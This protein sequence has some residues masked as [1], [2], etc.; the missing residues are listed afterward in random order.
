[1]GSGTGPAR[2]SAPESFHSVSGCGR[3]HSPVRTLSPAL[4]I[5]SVR[6][7][8]TGDQRLGV[9][10]RARRPVVKRQVPANATVGSVQAFGASG[11][12]H[13]EHPSRPDEPTLRTGFPDHHVRAGTTSPHCTVD[14]DLRQR[15]GGRSQPG[16][17]HRRRRNR[18]SPRDTKFK[19]I[20]QTSEIE[21]LPQHHRVSCR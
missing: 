5:R 4:S 2:P 3:G 1:M 19:P 13:K 17:P 7:P 11:A 15:D 21:A 9:W 12:P 18:V 14:W 16:P 10:R 6:S 8:R 20:A